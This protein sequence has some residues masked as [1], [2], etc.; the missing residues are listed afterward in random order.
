[1]LISNL[2][3]SLW[4]DVTDSKGVNKTTICCVAYPVSATSH[5]K[6]KLKQGL[7][8]I[9]KD[10]QMCILKGG[11]YRYIVSQ[12]GRPVVQIVIPRRKIN[13][14]LIIENCRPPLCKSCRKAGRQWT[15]LEHLSICTS[16]NAAARDDTAFTVAVVDDSLT[17][18]LRSLFPRQG[19]DES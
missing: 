16:L 11:I 19:E 17:S 3:Y 10:K 2:T 1:M 9:C 12:I 6:R 8:H 13:S 5:S 18:L 15:P 7:N 14:E 4:S